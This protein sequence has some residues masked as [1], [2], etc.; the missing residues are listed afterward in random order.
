M[1]RKLEHEGE[2]T[3]RIVVMTAAVPPVSKINARPLLRGDPYKTGSSARARVSA[4]KRMMIPRTQAG[5]AR[6][7]AW[8]RRKMGGVY[9]RLVPLARAGH[10]Q[11]SPP[12]STKSG[13]PA[14]APSPGEDR[15]PA[16]ALHPWLAPRTAPSPRSPF[17]RT[18]GEPARFL[19]CVRRPAAQPTR[20][21]QSEADRD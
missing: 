1:A 19:C 15:L 9:Q 21:L 14:W 18:P 16:E 7:P 17:F 11:A 5:L 13:L 3:G 10:Q 6:R 4:W 12:R 2:S 20:R 8:V